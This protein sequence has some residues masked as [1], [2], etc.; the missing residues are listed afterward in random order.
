[1][2]ATDPEKMQLIR[3]KM[4][5]SDSLDFVVSTAVN[6]VGVNIN[7]ASKSLLGYVS[8]INKGIAEN[9]VCEVPILCHPQKFL[10]IMDHKAVTVGEKLYGKGNPEGQALPVAFCNHLPDGSGEQGLRCSGL[11]VSGWLR[12][13]GIVHIPDSTVIFKI[14][15]TLR[16]NLN[17][18][19]GRVHV[20]HA[21]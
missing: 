5:L 14:L 18:C 13:E 2:E 8:G 19:T 7:T 20:K 9:I 3:M 21:A 1:M 16:S 15:F 17:K 4:K 6:Q 10:A 11:I 12:R